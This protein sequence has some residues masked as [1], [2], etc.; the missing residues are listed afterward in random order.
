MNRF[1]YHFNIN[2]ACLFDLDV[3]I[4]MKKGFNARKIISVSEIRV[5]KN[6]EKI[7]NERLFL[8]DPIS[9]NWK[10]LNSLYETKIIKEITRYESLS[11]DR[12]KSILEIYSEIFK[13][14]SSMEKLN[15]IDLIN[16]FHKI[17]YFS[18]ISIESLSQFW[19]EWKN[20][21]ALNQ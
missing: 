19:N 2:Q 14:I 13:T 21:R 3:L 1:L 20:K 4:L 9:K 12:F 11:K 16:F 5:D 15:K 8:F 6:S 7:S 17:S 10:T 18:F